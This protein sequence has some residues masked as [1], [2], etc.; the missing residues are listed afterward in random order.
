MVVV[1]YEILGCFAN[2]T[3]ASLDALGS[4]QGFPGPS[5]LPQF[6]GLVIGSY[7]AAFAAV[8]LL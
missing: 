4:F 2:G 3:Q 5:L 7:A 6:F 1:W 8:F